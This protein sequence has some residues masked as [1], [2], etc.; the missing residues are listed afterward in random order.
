MRREGY[1]NAFL[2]PDVLGAIKGM[3]RRVAATYVE[4]AG[5]YQQKLVDWH[6]IEDEASAPRFF[7]EAR[8]S[9]DLHQCLDVD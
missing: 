6:L 9:P 3:L 7:E 5:L 1:V 2:H 4:W 8:G